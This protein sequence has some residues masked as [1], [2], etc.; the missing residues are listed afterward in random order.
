M[1]G[2][3]R[4]VNID[5]IIFGIREKGRR[6]LL[7]QVRAVNDEDGLVNRGNLQEVT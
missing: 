3:I 7:I 2:I 5:H 4:L 1:S 6:G